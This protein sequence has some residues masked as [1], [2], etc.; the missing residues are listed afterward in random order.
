M[1]SESNRRSSQK[2]LSRM[3]VDG[4]EREDAIV[5]A[6]QECQAAIDAG[7]AINREAMASKYPAIR[8]ELMACLDGLEL[9]R[10]STDEESHASQ[11]SP[12]ATL[13][14][15]RIVRELGRGGM[16]VVY[17]AEQLSIGRRV[18]LKVL[19][20]AAMLDKRQIER[21]QNEARAAATLEHPHIVPVHFVGIERGVHYYAMRLIEGKNLAEVMVELKDP[22]QADSPLSQ[23]A[24]KLLQDDSFSEPHKSRSS[25]SNPETVKDLG[26][27]STGPMTDRGKR[28][29]VYFESIARLGKQVAEALEFAHGYGIIH[30]DI[31][32]AN[33]MLD[34]VGDAWVADF[35]LARIEADAGMTM[36]GDLIGTLRYMSPEQT[37]ADQNM[38]GHRSDIYS[39]G[40]TLYELLTLKNMFHGSDRDTLLRQINFE[41][42]KTPSKID[43]AIPR[44]LE[45]IILKSVNKNPED[46]Y[47]KAQDFADDLQRFLS[48]E[49][50]QARRTPMTRRF[51]M[52]TRRH[53][54]IA[55]ATTVICAVVLIATTATGLIVASK[56]RNARIQVSKALV[57]RDEALTQA[58]E[59]LDI[60][61]DS[62]Q[63]SL[64][65]VDEMYREIATVWI[66]NDRELTNTQTNFLTRSATLFEQI[67]E[68]FKENPDFKFAAGSAYMN[69]GE[70]Q[71]RLVNY[72]K[73]VVAFVTAQKL[74]S[75]EL[76]RD[77]G[78]DILRSNLAKT[79]H[80]LGDVHIFL[81]RADAAKLAFALAK[82]E[83]ETLVDNQPK[84]TFYQLRLASLRYGM[85]HMEQM[86]GADEEAIR[87]SNETLFSVGKILEENPESIEARRSQIL[88]KLVVVRALRRLG[89]HEEAMQSSQQIL[90][91]T[92]WEFKD[93]ADDRNIARELAE[94]RFELGFSFLS[95]GKLE[96]AEQ[97]LKHSLEEIRRSFL[98]DGTPKEF[99]ILSMKGEI[100][101]D[102]MEPRAFAQYAQMQAGL[103]KVM[104]MT[105]RLKEGY[106]L[107]DESLR[108]GVLLDA[109]F[110]GRPEFIGAASNAA[111]LFAQIDLTNPEFDDGVHDP[112]LGNLTRSDLQGIQLKQIDKVY[113]RLQEEAARPKS[114]Q[115]YLIAASGLGAGYA[116]L[117]NRSGKR[118][119]AMAKY[120]EVTETLRQ[121]ILEREDADP[122]KKILATYEQQ[123]QEMAEYDPENPKNAFSFA[124]RAFQFSAKGDDQNALKNYERSL[125]LDPDLV[126]ALNGMGW[127]LATCPDEELRD[128]SR[129]VELAT[130]ACELTDW[131]QTFYFDTLAAGYAESGDFDSAVQWQ[132]KATEGAPPKERPDYQSRLDVYR[133]GMPFRE[134]K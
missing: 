124:G 25:P 35:G 23:T 20:Y 44:D 100:S 87:I 50:V 117:L 37:F 80:G 133:D 84:N 70:A 101:E 99:S 130:R 126:V 10:L 92:R 111:T 86:S 74:L 57:E 15:F 78:N 109:L 66:A 71:S 108:T 134:D 88:L 48:H 1:N 89:R 123:A 91:E 83:Y 114:S 106:R 8:D 53:P 21:F 59:N 3:L 118:D 12:S 128:G 51:Q 4:S 18:A 31:K 56:E 121:A 29:K 24:S 104:L 46:R 90:K 116:R 16:G 58:N 7:K 94:L 55:L 129:A 103:G 95:L 64:N 125:E 131:K 122:L 63:L 19:P 40:A 105:N 52:W 79:L 97:E 39:L 112:L 93:S 45:T 34:D 65:A 81:D 102:Q 38:V 33:I 42:P 96:K 73:A 27:N 49:P 9:M 113:V 2:T 98:F 43:P 119:R 11:I 32:P 30:R 22:S 5:R 107:L 75:Q 62:L 120:Q 110:P 41:N 26:D 54:A 115:Q 36:T 72:D 85:A 77:P 47:A 17:E 61:K 68:R 67:A 127:I 82:D 14:D 76:E 60:A 69:V 13:G 28:G 132:T 6:L